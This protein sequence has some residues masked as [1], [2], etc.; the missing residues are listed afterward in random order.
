M[1]LEPNVIYK[2]IILNNPS[3]DGYALFSDDLLMF[4]ATVGKQHSS[5][6]WSDVEHLVLRARSVRPILK[7]FMVYVVPTD[8][9]LQLPACDSMRNNGVKVCFGTFDDDDFHTAYFES[10]N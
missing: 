4:Q 1:Q 8:S 9:K 10:L 6:L 7:V 3:I 5:G 2:S